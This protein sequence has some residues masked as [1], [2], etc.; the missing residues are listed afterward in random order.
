MLC[1][2]SR[3]GCMYMEGPR[4]GEEKA[5]YKISVMSNWEWRL[6]PAGGDLWKWHFLNITATRFLVPRL[7][8][9]CHS[10]PRS[11]FYFLLN[12]GELDIAVVHEVLCKWCCMISEARHKKKIEFLLGCLLLGTLILGTQLLSYEEAQTSPCKVSH[13]KVI[14]KGP[15]AKTND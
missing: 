9:F 12:L 5:L 3:W 14:L 15:I 13:K 11:E 8:E 2:A 1:F 6:R 4:V 10:P 7:S